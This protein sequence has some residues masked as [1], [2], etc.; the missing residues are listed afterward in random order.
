[1]W[2]LYL[3]SILFL[4]CGDQQEQ[5]PP[6]H[7]SIQEVFE[8]YDVSADYDPDRAFNYSLPAIADID[9]FTWPSSVRGIRNNNWGNVEKGSNWEGLGDDTDVR[10]ANFEHPIFGIRAIIRITSNYTSR[11]GINTIEGWTKRWAPPHE[12]KTNKY[13]E[14]LKERTGECNLDVNDYEF[15][16]KFTR[17]V[18]SME[19]GTDRI[20]EVWDDSFFRVAWIIK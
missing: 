15:M 11:Y 4:A 16:K 14:F 6:E 3:I 18:C 5:N 7:E 20:D 12:N 9:R 13:A 1:M 2:R 10:F 17:A 8:F 19:N